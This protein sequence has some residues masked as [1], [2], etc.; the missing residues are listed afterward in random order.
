MNHTH[1]STAYYVQ[2]YGEYE[3]QASDVLGR[4]YDWFSKHPQ[5]T[6]QPELLETIKITIIELQ[7]RLV[8]ATSMILHWLYW[9]QVDPTN[10]FLDILNDTGKFVFSMQLGKDYSD[11]YTGD[12][13][14]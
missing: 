9:Y 2:Y 4:E 11:T 14:S 13:I 8:I 1:L 12:I 10:V 5:Y 7:T 6:L 3:L